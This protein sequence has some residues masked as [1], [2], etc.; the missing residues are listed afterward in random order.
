ME[1]ARDL[2]F[3]LIAMKMGK[4]TDA[5]L[6]KVAGDWQAKPEELLPTML[7][8]RGI[9]NDKDREVI[10]AMVDGA[11]TVSLKQ[12]GDTLA[13]FGGTVNFLE[14]IAQR[15][16]IDA[17]QSTFV[18]ADQATIVTD[19]QATMVSAPGSLPAGSSP[20]DVPAVAQSEGRYDMPKE[21][22]SGGMGKIM[23]VRDKHL[24]RQVAL[25]E[26]RPDML[27][28]TMGATRTG[29][30]S[31]Q[32]LTIPIVAR[33]MQEARVTGS[34]EHPSI[35][36]IYEIGY[37][38]DGTLYYTMKLV[39]G[40][41]LQDALNACKSLEDRLKL[42]PHIRNMCHAI[43]YA[44]SKGVI[45]RD[46]K[47]MNIMVGE[48]GETIVIDWGIAK[49]LNQE[50]IH[51]SDMKSTT[52]AAKQGDTLS[53][54]KTM[55]GQAMGSPYY[56]PPEQAEGNI[57][58]INATSDVY[59]LGCVLYVLLTGQLPF[60]GIRPYDYLEKV[61]TD[62]PKPIK[63]VEPN[64]PAEL[65]AIA[66]RA[67]AKDQSIRYQTAKELADEIENFL[68]GGI[69][70]AYTYGFKEHLKRFLAKHR[71]TLTAAAVTVSAILAFGVFSYIQI[72]IQRNIAVDARNKEE[73]A[74]KDAESARDKEEIARKAETVAKEAE[75]VQRETAE[76]RLY[77]AN[78]ALAKT[79]IDENRMDQA[80]AH[81][82]ESPAAYRN[83]EW[84]HLQQ[85]ANAD[86][87]TFEGGGRL[88]RFRK[89]N[90]SIVTGSSKGTV[91]VYSTATGEQIR[92]FTAR[93][94]TNYDVAVSGDES[95]VAVASDSGFAV[96]DLESGAEKLKKAHAGAPPENFMHKTAMS[97]D[98][99]VAAA[100]GTDKLVH[101]WNVASGEEMHT[102][103]PERIEGVQLAFAPDGNLVVVSDT[104]TD[105]GWAGRV[106]LW[107]L[108]AKSETNSFTLNPG[109]VFKSMK[110][111]PDGSRLA[112]G[113]GDS[114]HLWSLAPWTKA[115]ETTGGAERSDAMAF[116]PDGTHLAWGYTDGVVTVW[117]LAGGAVA[118]TITAH[119]GAVNGV[120]YSADGSEIATGGSD[121]YLR[122]WEAKAG[123]RRGEFKGHN[124]AV[125]V[126]A[127]SPDGSRLASGGFATGEGIYP[128]KIWSTTP[129]L[130][131]ADLRAVSFSPAKGLIAGIKGTSAGLWD[132]ASGRM[133]G[134]VDTGSDKASAVAGSPDGAVIAT[135]VPELKDGKT[136]E[137]IALW[138]AADGAALHT[139]GAFDG[140]TAR[141]EFSPSGAH[142]IA[143]TGNVLHLWDAGTGQKLNEFADNRAAAFAADGQ[144]LAV[145]DTAGNIS[146]IGM[147]RG[148]IEFAAKVGEKIPESRL[149]FN[150][151]GTLLAGTDEALV[152]KSNAGRVH[153]WDVPGGAEK[154]LLEG[155]G[156][157]VT[158]LGFT[159]DGMRLATGRFSGVVQVWDPASGKE[160]LTFAGGHVRAVTAV[161][162]TADGKRLVTASTDGTFKLWDTENAKQILTLHSGALGMKATEA[163]PARVVFGPADGMLA[164]ITAPRGIR[165]YVLEAFPWDAAAYPNPAEPSFDKRVEAYK[166]AAA[167]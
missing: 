50:D 67:M 123:A 139:L 86:L 148:D 27:S 10:E 92:E 85:L 99:S 147:A 100:L 165:P 131:T 59:A 21:H 19:N 96:F 97:A 83:W 111:S 26:L 38:P 17:D 8:E 93:A 133:I 115:G 57:D 13:T 105:S 43:A 162:F 135:A 152:D 76:R 101:A 95:S 74:R 160:I 129:D 31:S 18:L 159:A 75:I 87:M 20:G 146:V 124:E 46:I 3:A 71:T 16:V 140:K 73:I 122:T 130:E 9:M 70:M 28:G 39:K 112:L 22:A 65:V 42:L 62:L 113:T 167:K 94:G 164:T 53:L 132:A 77:Y 23:L 80:R 1:R 103:T 128:T 154:V 88:A 158:S 44:H 40:K 49:I 153:L 144:R 107:D 156:G 89:D 157:R 51:A 90:T 117:D 29:A 54:A 66:E 52:K 125:F 119:A 34:L 37:R 136:L 64:A 155:D 56:M 14:E 63:E 35:I 24:D 102:I 161:G 4:L 126:V 47:P 36:P 141:I 106:G 30:P 12:G 118:F 120:A 33:F 91:R 150:P 109:Q 143:K 98:G 142:V 58:K 25:K 145:T 116:S 127:Y 163:A 48:F 7:L 166:R 121:K 5:D 134:S 108:A 151:A 68:N 104:Y 81:L 84:G 11:M 78:V 137:T 79:A 60:I 45:H 61:I 149:L 69:V 82:M 114:T 138:K 55:Y 32:M 110:L 6:T 41:T 15:T 2:L 72:T